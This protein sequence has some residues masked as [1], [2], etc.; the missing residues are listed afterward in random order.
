MVVLPDISLLDASNILSYHAPSPAAE[1]AQCYSIPY[2]AFAFVSHFI[3]VYTMGCAFFDRKWWAPWNKRS[4]PE[5]KGLLKRPCCGI[6]LYRLMALCVKV[7]ITA[8]LSIYNI[9]ECRDTFRL[10]A[11]WKVLMVCFDGVTEAYFNS[12][13]SGKKASHTRTMVFGIQFVLLFL[14]GVSIGI[15]GVTKLAQQSWNS[16]R[17][18]HTLTWVFFGVLS[19]LVAIS[20]ILTIIKFNDFD[21]PATLGLMLLLAYLAGAAYSDWMI[22]I[23][24]G[25]MVGVPDD[26][27]HEN[28]K[29]IAGAYFAAKHL[30]MLFR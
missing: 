1:A 29:M 16:S 3:T 20:A 19:A 12:D 9:Y 10:L 6:I 25:N 18:I 15:A 5:P 4:P 14:P 26:A 8:A 11:V 13:R 22:G 2:G 30:D 28:N 23:I 7:A 21:L 24:T 17:N 27:L